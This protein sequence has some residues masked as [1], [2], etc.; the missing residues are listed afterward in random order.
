MC[1]VSDVLLTKRGAVESRVGEA[2]IRR[3]FL[4]KMRNRGRPWN[5][6]QPEAA[7]RPRPRRTRRKREAVSSQEKM[8]E[9]WQKTTRNAE[10]NLQPLQKSKKM[11]I[12]RV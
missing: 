3:V 11:L 10:K 1:L 6:P 5:A 9:M 7:G 12:F 2:S 4:H 8:S